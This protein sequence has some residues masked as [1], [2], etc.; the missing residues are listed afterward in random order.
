MKHAHQLT[1]DLF[2]DLIDN[3]LSAIDICIKHELAIDQLAA[4]VDSPEFTQASRQLADIE[5]KR[6][7]ATAPLRRRAALQTLETIAQQHPTTPTHTETVRKAAAQLA[8]PTKSDPAPDPDPG[9]SDQQPHPTPGRQ[10]HADDASPPDTPPPARAQ[11][12][13]GDPEDSEPRHAA[14]S[15][16]S[17]DLP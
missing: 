14:Q 1:P 6:I 17:K 15:P 12:E 10:A 9:P 13:H 16:P 5:R 3:R 4:I 11:P 2:H 8:R 7:E